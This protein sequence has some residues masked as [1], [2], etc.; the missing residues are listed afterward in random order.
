MA[1][2]ER[3][4][5]IELRTDVRSLSVD[6]KEIKHNQSSQIEGLEKNKADKK[7]LENYVPKDQF[8]GFRATVATWGAAGLLVLGALEVGFNTI[9]K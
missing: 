4:L 7:E 1:R 2:D 3:D 5:L 8:A 6:I 9:W